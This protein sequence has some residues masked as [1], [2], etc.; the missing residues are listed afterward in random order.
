MCA[1][2]LGFLFRAF[3]AGWGFQ[4]WEGFTMHGLHGVSIIAT[5]RQSSRE[6]CPA[7]ACDIE[8][9]SCVHTLSCMPF[10][11]SE[12]L[13]FMFRG[14][15]SWGSFSQSGLNPLLVPPPPKKRMKTFSGQIRHTC[16]IVVTSIS[17]TP[18][19]YCITERTFYRESIY[20]SWGSFSQ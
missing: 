19:S 2:F 17:V 9:K 14:E 20:I 7:W 6:L 5:A 8:V 11:F 12:H 1:Y 10:I 15:T 13:Y 3:T 4:R 16:D 18:F